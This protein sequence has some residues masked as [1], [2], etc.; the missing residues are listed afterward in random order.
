MEGRFEYKVVPAPARGVK[1]RGLRSGEERFAHALSSL[2]N[3]MAAE[4]WDYLRSDTLP[5]EERQG[6][7]G[8]R[9]VYHNM[10]VFRRALAV[11]E[12]A[13]PL[14]ADPT[15][16]PEPERTPEPFMGFE[17]GEEQFEAPAA[18]VLSL[19]EARKRLQDLE[20]EEDAD[21]DEPRGVAAE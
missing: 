12:E 13:E 14:Q 1:A 19:L 9:T 3:E 18:A 20:A 4:G 8:S 7:T 11:L 10:L 17:D 21:A 16:E 6:L 15:P 5:A 2:M